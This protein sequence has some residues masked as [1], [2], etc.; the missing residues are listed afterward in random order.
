MEISFSHKTVSA[1]REIPCPVKRI[2]ETM[3]SVVPDTN[4]DIGRIAAS[5]TSVLLKSKEAG[6]QEIRVSGEVQT[7]LLYITENEANVSFI[8]LRKEFEMSFE[9]E[10]VE[11]ENLIQVR[12]SVGSVETHVPNPR[13]VAVTVELLGTATCY[14]GGD[15]PVETL[16]PENAGRLL[17]CKTEQGET[18]RIHAVCEKTFAWNEQYRFPDGKPEPSQ[19][20]FQNAA[21]QVEDIQQVGNR[22]V[23]KGT[24][25]IEV[26]YLSQEVN[27]PLRTVFR[28]PFSQIVDTGAEENDGSTAF[29]ELTGAYYD[30]VDTISGEKAL[31]VELHAVLQMQSRCRQEI[32]YIADVYSNRFPCV[33]SKQTAKLVRVSETDAVHIS[34]DGDL[35]IAEDCEDVVC[36]LPTLLPYEQRSDRLKTSLSLDVIYR[37]RSGNLAAVK[38]QLDLPDHM[39]EPGYRVCFCRIETVNLRP[40]GSTLHCKAEIVLMCQRTDTDEGTDVSSV[41]LD[42]DHACSL[43]DYPSITIVHKNAG[44]LWELAKRYHSS[45]EEIEALQETLGE[46]TTGSLLI[47]RES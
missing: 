14:Q 39:L 38:R 40:E 31:D 16:V 29:V 17:H 3:E 1:Y 45:V 9:A 32:R 11:N 43:T 30:L 21:F 13:K 37:N 27:Y 47:P 2:Q 20:V 46:E 42:E 34:G 22:V 26:C 4:E 44:D 33:C 35:E 24:V 28:S 36:V 15:M 7:T 18:S 10:T 23:L 8:Q 12:L 41:I 6:E 19:L 5:R 25:T